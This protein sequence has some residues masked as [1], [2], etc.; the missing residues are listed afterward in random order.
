LLKFFKNLNLGFKI[1]GGFAILILI[2]G[3]M[4]L[5]G[6]QGLN[7]VD[8]DVQISNDA[9]G[10]A[11]TTLEIRQNEKNFM[12]QE[13]QIYID[14][15][16]QMVSSMVASGDKTKEL[17]QEEADKKR[18]DNMQSLANQY[19][20]AAISYADSLFQQNELRTEF[21][22]V[23]EELK[24]QIESLEKAQKEEYDE[25][26]ADMNSGMG[27]VEIRDIEQKLQT[28]LLANQLVQNVDNIGRQ[29]RNYII[30]LA[31][32]EGQEK[33]A[34]STLA[35]FQTAKET[36]T[37]LKN[38][39]NEEKDI[40]TA[41]GIL[42]QLNNTE[43]VFQQ[44]H[45]IELTKDQNKATM[46]TK[47]DEFLASANELQDLQLAEMEEGQTAAIRNLIIALIVA[48]II[49]A[50]IAFI[51]TRSITKPV[52]LG[53]EFA[54]EI[55]QGNLRAK[56]IDVNSEDE[57]GTLANALNKMQDNLRGVIEDVAE[58][59]S[60]L[61]SS[62]EELSASSEEISASAEQV[63]TAIQEVA[64]GAEEQTAQI[65]ETKGNVEDLAGR[66]DNVGEKSGEMDEK[67][68]NVMDNI[69]EGNTSINNSIDQVREVK[70]QSQAV[71]NRID[72]LGKLSEQIGDIVELINGISAQTNLLA[73]NAAIE[74]ARA[75]E[76]GRGFSVVADEIRELAEE[77]SDATENIASLINEIQDGVQ[78]TI[79]Q[80]N[81]AEEAVED[82]VDA[83]KTTEN[84]FGEIDSAAVSLR[85]LIKDITE[86]AEDMAAKSSQVEK[87]VDEVASV[88]EQASSNAEEVA[89]S[90]EEQSAST[91][92]IVKASENLSEMAQKLS[93]KVEQ[94]EI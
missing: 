35:A 93:S 38:S 71:S 1:G 69:K 41:E 19:K 78:D 86:A 90:S 83:I 60:D 25:L 88:S 63:G 33:Y 28:L 4:A 30:N 26:I 92:E 8:H 9:A 79:K 75:G 39:F 68:G 81:K 32:A 22:A 74:A 64:S 59:A 5:V 10:F 31:D 73:L 80:M 44:I 51:I 17:M 72:D 53:V 29:E 13:E 14:N 43:N 45:E 85:S 57:I 12:L 66:I 21:V 65:E 11:E 47:A 27:N 82:G 56:K 55:A 94:F 24:S 18:I 42:N 37:E 61:S 67:A 91:E 52:N 3:I 15:I 34:N 2:A 48:L 87:A 6:Y 70:N 46:E 84:S 54:K 62:S 76:A 16:D 36:A 23:E 20:T 58:I 40:K 49:G 89:A 50:L 7:N 77:S